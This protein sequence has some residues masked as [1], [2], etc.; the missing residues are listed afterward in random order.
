MADVRYVGPHD[1]VR[2]PL[3]SGL[4]AVCER[5]ATVSV[6]D[7]LADGLLEQADNWQAVKAAEKRRG[8][9]EEG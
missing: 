6:P 2:V 3:P 8:S 9:G 1:A 5:G 4:D 7:S